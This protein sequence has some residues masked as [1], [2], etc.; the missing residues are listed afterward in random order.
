MIF[1]KLIF[2]VTFIAIL[3]LPQLKAEDDANKRNLQDRADDQQVVILQTVKKTGENLDAILKTRDLLDQDILELREC[4]Q[5][6]Q[7]LLVPKSVLTEKY[8]PALQDLA[9]EKNQKDLRD[10]QKTLET[11]KGSKDEEIEKSIKDIDEIQNELLGTLLDELLDEL[12]KKLKQPSDKKNQQDLKASNG[13]QI[14]NGIE[15]IDRI[16]NE[17]T[18]SQAKENQKK[19]TPNKLQKIKKKNLHQLNNIT[20]GEY[21]QMVPHKNK[22]NVFKAIN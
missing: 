19:S 1:P 12:L 4:V 7:A 9:Q 20:Q 18:I 21:H 6:L 15:D 10:E 14:Q 5:A 11:L 13:E 22:L 2:I 17:T 16:L 8:L 3:M